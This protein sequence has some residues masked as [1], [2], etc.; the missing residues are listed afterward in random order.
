M[1]VVAILLVMAIVMA[2]AGIPGYLIGKRSGVAQP[3]VAFVPFLGLWIVL[4]ESMR[5]SGWLACLGLIPYV[6][7]LVVIVWT[8]IGAPRAHG[9]SG[10]WTVALI[11]PLVNIV[12]YW[13]YAL[14]MSERALHPTAPAV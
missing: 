12:G 9:R 8:A 6:G 13:I 1:T 10:W 5:R 14:T 11:V 4:F 7:G 2:I 3:L